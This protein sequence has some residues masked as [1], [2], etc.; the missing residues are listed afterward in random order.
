M[1]L[2]LESLQLPGDKVSTM[3]FVYRPSRV[4]FQP[5]SCRPIT[6][7]L[8]AIT[9]KRNSEPFTENLRL[10][11]VTSKHETT[12]LPQYTRV[13]PCCR[14]LPSAQTQPSGS[15][16]SLPSTAIRHNGKAKFHHHRLHCP[17]HPSLPLR[18]TNSETN[19]NSSACRPSTLALA[20]LTRRAGSGRRTSS[21]THTPP[22]WAT[23]LS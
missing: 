18:P 13:D 10:H 14:Q 9:G 7:H 21:A 11:A 16:A 19:R 20:T 22:S 17:S 6:S 5:M 2:R 15:I 12:Q 4:Y 23:D 3:Y 8:L 1:N